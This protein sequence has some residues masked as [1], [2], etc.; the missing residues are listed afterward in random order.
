MNDIEKYEFDR[1]GYLVIKN[2][3]KEE[4]VK[5]LLSSIDLLK[6]CNSKFEK[7]AS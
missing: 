2:L 1:M 5:N 7:A 4:Q 3:L 6:A